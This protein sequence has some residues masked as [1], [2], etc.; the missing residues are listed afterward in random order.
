VTATSTPGDPARILIIGGGTVGLYAALGLQKRLQPDEADI[1]LVSPESFMLYQPFLPEAASGSIEPRHVVVP[2]RPIL[3][4]VRLITGRVTELDHGTRVARVE[5]IGGGGFDLH[6][7]QVVVAV[8]SVSRVLPVPG[9]VEHGIGFKTL[10][11]AIDLRNRVL[12]A[13]DLAES[14]ADQAVRRR[15]L[16]FVFVGGGYAGIEAMAELEDMARSATRYYRTV[17]HEDM[18]WVLVEAAGHILPELSEDLGEYTLEQ[19]GRRGFLVHLNTRLDAIENGVARLSDGS[20]YETG[21]V[22]WTA[23]VKPDPILARYGLPLDDRGRM[24]ADEF[25][26]VRGADG[27]W[28]AGD[29]AAVPDLVEGGFTPPTAQ[30]ALR[31]ARRLAQNVVASL[32]DEPLAPFRYR[33]LGALASLGLYKGVARVLGLKLR[34]FPAWFLHRTYH[35][36]RVPTLG[37]KARVITD[38]TVALFFRRDVVQLASLQHPREQILLASGSPGRLAGA[39]DAAGPVSE[40]PGDHDPGGEQ[41]DQDRAQHAAAAAPREHGGRKDGVHDGRGDVGDRDR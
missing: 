22:V 30:H 36:S 6:Y 33:N 7:D 20:V 34:G 3:K 35:V 11:E 39:G 18:R 14:S 24:I 16:T 28:T 15:A 27:A 40:V 38:W 41:H 1:I 13:M 5:P 32:R 26:R 19:L 17:G 9:L 2:L 8:G 12:A 25:L 10:A 23:G 37:R 21:T 29:A 4:R 31:Q